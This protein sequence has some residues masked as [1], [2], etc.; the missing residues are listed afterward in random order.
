MKALISYGVV[1]L[2]FVGLV[3]CTVS[4]PLDPIQMSGNTPVAFAGGFERIVVDLSD[5]DQF[6]QYQNRFRG[7]ESVRVSAEATN[8][9]GADQ[10]LRIYVSDNE[11]LTAGNAAT[12]GTW[13]ATI[14]IP[15]TAV[16]QE[17][18]ATVGEAAKRTVEGYLQATPPVF[19]VYI[20]STATEDGGL[21]VRNITFEPGSAVFSI[22]RIRASHQGTSVE[23]RWAQ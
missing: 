6:M 3:G 20:L 21:S 16:D 23:I 22:F 7:F 19:Y 18:S 9:T 2:A 5:N 17:V 15:A 11:G 10:Q 14:D 1:V 12:T 4:V 13:L 8:V